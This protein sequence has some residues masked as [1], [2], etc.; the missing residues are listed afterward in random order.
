[1]ARAIRTPRGISIRRTS[2]EKRNWR[3]R[4]SCRRSVGE[5]FG[6]P[7]GADPKALVG[8]ED[9]LD[10]IVDHG[11]QRD[12][13]GKGDQDQDRKDEEP[14]AV[15]LGLHRNTSRAGWAK[16]ESEAGL[17]S[18]AVLDRGQPR[19]GL[20]G[21]Q[22][23]RRPIA[24]H[25]DGQPS[26]RAGRGSVPWM[27]LR[28]RLSGCGQTNDPADGWAASNFCRRSLPSDGRSVHFA[29]NALR[30]PERQAPG[31]AK[32]RNAVIE[33]ADMSTSDHITSRSSA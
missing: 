2:P 11:H 27:P 33:A 29:R 30:R 3:Q 5:D 1:M 23:I 24:V 12:D 9:V 31:R 4:A 8:A 32:C 20:L 14:G 15:V 21:H 7:L 19:R 26:R 17:D 18:D 22:A 13:R 28:E 10:R 6:E 16:R 25:R